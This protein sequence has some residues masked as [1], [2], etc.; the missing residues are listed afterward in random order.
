M[1]KKDPYAP[2]NRVYPTKKVN[3]ESVDTAPDT[4]VVEEVPTGTISEVKAW[5]GD[6]KDRARLA[7]DAE[8]DKD[9]PRVTFV[10][11]LEDMLSE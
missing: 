4:E 2:V 5:V 1:S 9:D 7:L 10:E 6:D 3:A 8:N 11:Y